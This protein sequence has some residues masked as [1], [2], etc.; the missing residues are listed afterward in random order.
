MKMCKQVRLEVARCASVKAGPKP[1]IFEVTGVAP[2]GVRVRI[3]Y[4]AM[5]PDIGDEPQ[6][7]PFE[8]VWLDVVDVPAHCYPGAPRLSER[9]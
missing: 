2:D 5:A 8:D 4:T 7:V 1:H 3:E 6:P 9:A